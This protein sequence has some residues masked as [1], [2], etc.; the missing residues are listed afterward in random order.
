MQKIPKTF[1]PAK[2]EEIHVNFGFNYVFACCKATPIRFVNNINEVLGP[3]RQNLLNDIQDPS[4][5]Y[6]WSMENQ[7]HASR[8]HDYLSKNNNDISIYRE[9]KSKTKM[10]EI[11][12]G[13]E[14][15]FQCG[16]CN[17]KFSSQWE[18]DVNSKIYP[19]FTDRFFYALDEKNKNTIVDT[20]NWLSEVE[21]LDT[22]SIVGGEPLLNK[23]FFKIIEKVKSNKLGFATN[24]S[25][26]QLKIDQVLELANHYSDISLSVSIDSTGE[27]AEFTRYGMNW[28]TMRDNLLYLVTNS[29]KNVKI[30]LLSLMTSSTIRGLKEMT[31]FVERLY[32]INNNLVWQLFD[33]RDPKIHSMLT[34]PTEMKPEILKQLDIINTMPNTEFAE[35]VQNSIINSKFN[36]TMYKELQEFTNEF[37][38]RKNIEVPECLKD[39]KKP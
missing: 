23:N 11:S 19:V 25:C 3:Q 12:L 36:R 5:N 9:N 1:C 20:V 18:S 2:W 17:P 28:D 35:L 37:S 26:S 6:C 10:V 16:Y 22:L 13:N 39:L 8:R 24:L 38:Q 21:D 31:L 29:P 7:G 14:C 34:L 33:C 30:N 4:C 32:N 27:L 15:N